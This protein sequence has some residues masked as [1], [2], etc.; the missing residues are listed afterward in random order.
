LINDINKYYKQ[1]F[2]RFESDNIT[3]RDTLTIRKTGN[4]LI[5]VLYFKDSINWQFGNEN[6]IHYIF[7]LNG[8]GINTNNGQ[9]I[10][11]YNNDIKKILVVLGA[12]HPD[13]AAHELG[14]NLGLQHTFENKPNIH[15]YP[16]IL[17]HKNRVLINMGTTKNIMDYIRTSENIRRYFFKYQIYH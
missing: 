7:V 8:R 6:N 11:P 9:A 5:N 1:T 14:H 12:T 3:Y 4:D 16:Y 2:N 17:S 13:V 10:T 15:I